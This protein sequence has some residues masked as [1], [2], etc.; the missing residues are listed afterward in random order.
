MIPTLEQTSSSVEYNWESRNKPLHLVLSAK[1]LQSAPPLCDP[2]GTA[3]HKVPLSMGFSRKEYWSR[4]PFLSPGDLPNP[5]IEPRSPA[6]GADSLPAEPWGKP[7]NTGGDPP[8]PGIEPGSPCRQ[9]LYQ[10]S[11]QGSLDLESILFWP[12]CQDNSMEKEKFFPTNGTET[13]G[14]LWA[15]EWIWTCTLHHIQKVFKVY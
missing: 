12:W 5:Q 14:Y 9:I 10:L 13:T 2:L 7:K 8:D 11:Y 3:A 1:S 6:L 4:L 15:E